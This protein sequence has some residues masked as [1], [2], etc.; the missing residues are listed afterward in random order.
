M[1]SRR[2]PKPPFPVRIGAGLL[3]N[4][5]EKET[6]NAEERQTIALVET[7]QEMPPRS[8]KAAQEGKEAFLAQAEE[9]RQKLQQ[10]KPD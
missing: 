3:M 5:K 6:F 10:L 4:P 9:L 1:E 7:F 2:S 8:Q